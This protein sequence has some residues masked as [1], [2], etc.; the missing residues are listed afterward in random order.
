MGARA[1]VMVVEGPAGTGKPGYANQCTVEVRVRDGLNAK[2][3]PGT[4]GGFCPGLSIHTEPN[5]DLPVHT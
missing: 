5:A 1:R 2:S 3:P 4:F